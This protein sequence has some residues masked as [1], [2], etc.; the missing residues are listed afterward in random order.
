MLRRAAV[1]KLSSA[2]TVWPSASRR[3]HMCDPTKPAAPE[4]TIRKVPP[5]LHSS[6][7]RRD[8]GETAP[9]WVSHATVKTDGMTTE[10]KQPKP[11]DMVVLVGLPPGFLDDL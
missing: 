4:T 8:D 1:R 3:S 6:E 9:L 5:S 10:D 7:A 2:T 11:G